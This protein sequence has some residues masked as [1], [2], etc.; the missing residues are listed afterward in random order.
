[1]WRKIAYA[2]FL[3]LITLS[4][5]CTMCCHP[6]DYNGPVYDCDN[7]NMNV[8]AGSILEGRDIQYSSTDTIQEKTEKTT[9]NKG[10]E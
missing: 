2:G 9:P 10:Q 5:G 1:M 3:G 4:Y 6:Y 7:Q 8:R